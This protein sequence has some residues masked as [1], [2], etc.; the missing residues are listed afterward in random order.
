[1]DQ[2][3]EQ[4]QFIGFFG[5]FKETYKIISTYRQIF[6]QITLS[7]IL[8]LS[9]VFLAHLE[10][11][12]YLFRKIITNENAL[13]QTPENTKKYHTLSD[14]ISSEWT[15]FWVFKILYFVFFLIL[16]LISTSAI[17]YSVACIYTSKHMSFKKVISIVP[18]VWKRLMITF[19]WNFIIVFAFNLLALL[20]FFFWA[21]LV[22]FTGV[23]IVILCIL[24]IIYLA[25]FIYISV[26]WHLASVISV[27]EEDYGIRAM[28]KSKELIKGK[29]GVSTAIYSFLNLCFIVIQIGFERHVVLG[30]GSLVIKTIEAIIFF[31]LLSVLILVSLTA[32]TVVYFICKSFHH[33]NIDKSLLADHLEVYLGDYLLVKSKDVQL[34]NFDI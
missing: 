6:T 14:L 22:G 29:T 8:P 19:V 13:D 17:V 2:E 31:L 10:I 27:L 11:S 25:A 15:Y 5:I 12:E 20:I 21:T 34:E 32:Q 4:C 24:G 33:E 26:V 23:G 28:L 9:I 3:Q 7:I 16:S 18:K 30:R 1:M